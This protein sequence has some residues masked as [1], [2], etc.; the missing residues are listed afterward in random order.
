MAIAIYTI[1]H[2]SSGKQ[3]VGISSNLKR[4]WSDHKNSDGLC[5]VLHAAIKKH[6]IDN[7]EFTHIANAFTWEGACAIE[8]SLII[9]L[10]TKAPNGYNLTY[11]GDG[12][13]GFKHTKEECQRRSE[14]CPTRN[15]E[16]IKVI[17]DKLRGRKRPQ[18]SGKGNAM[19]GRTGLKSHMLKHIVIATNIETGSKLTLAGAQ[20][21]SLAGFNRAHVYACAKNKRKTHMNHIF[22]F[23]GEAHGAFC[24]V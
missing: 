20:E 6:G 1:T 23:K 11:G 18:N 22:E 21:I 17:A 7:F 4:R 10:G 16:V 9:E 8:R 14:R 2:K 24:E 3:Y 19:Y 15:P 13:Y 12:T 5:P